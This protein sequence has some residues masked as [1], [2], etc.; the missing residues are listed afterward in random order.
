[1]KPPVLDPRTLAALRQQV[2]ALAA[3]YTPEWRFEGTEDDPG[4]AIAELFCQMMEQAVDR[5]NSVPDNL[6]AHFLDMIGFRLPA[7][8]PASGILQFTVHETVAHPVPVPAATQAFTP[9]SQGDNIVYETERAIEA[10]PAQ[11]LDIYYADSTTDWIEKLDMAQPQAFFAPQGQN[12]QNHRFWLCQPDVLRLTGGCTIELELRQQARHLETQSAAYFAKQVWTYFSGGKEIPFDKVEAQN[13]RLLLEKNTP[14]ALEPDETGNF[15]IA[16]AGQPEAALYLSGVRLRSS[17]IGRCPADAVFAGDLPI[18]LSEGGYCFGRRPAPYGLFYIR[19]DVTLAK[20]GA[21]ANLRLEI[22]PIADAPSE[23]PLQY[24]FTQAIIDKREAVAQKPDDVY[25]AAVVWEYF[26]G[27]GWRQLAVTGDRN[28]FSC[29]RDGALELRFTVPDDLMETEVN[30]QMGYYI[31][32]RIAEV[33]NQFSVYPRWILPLV[34]AVS[35]SW[36]YEQPIPVQCCGAENNGSRIQADGNAT[37]LYLPA[38][39]PMEPAPR[40]M[41]FRFDRS[42]HAM[43]LSLLFEVIGRVPRTDKLVWQAYTGKK[44]EPAAS[45]DGTGNL[46]HTGQVLLYLPDSL[47]YAEFFGQGGYWLRVSRSSYFEMPAPR[48]ATVRLNTV[49]ARQVRAEEPLYFN[50][51]PYEADKTIQLLAAPVVSCAVWVDEAGALPLADAQALAETD[52]QNVTL[53]WEENQ[54]AHAWVRWQAVENLAL[55]APEQRAYVLEPQTGVLRF[56]NGQCGRVP[57]A[58]DGVIRVE[59]ASGGGTRGNVP[60]GKVDALVGSLPRISS[61]VNITPMGGGTDGLPRQRM[62]AIGNR[63]LRHRWRAAGAQDFEELILEAFPQVLHVR[64]FS[65]RDRQ[66]SPAAGHVTVVVDT[67]GGS[68]TTEELCRRVYEFLAARCICCLAAENRL[69]ICPAA[70]LTVSTR[71]SV[72]LDDLDYAAEVQREIIR[73]V[74]LL[75]Q[76]VWQHRQIG[77]QIRMDELWRTVRDTPGVAVIDQILAEGAYDKEGQPGLIPLEEG[78]DFPYAVVQNGI[79]QVRVK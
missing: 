41:Y 20:R 33:E 2:A 37:D 58:G 43:P 17:P 75:I 26:N 12:L 55:A 45:V 30:A 77:S 79:H 6:F 57:P 27:S 65:G 15:C 53:L 40:A 68:H 22:A 24:N 72:T 47:P 4:A 60:A 36:N 42:P 18:D 78:T 61:V 56:G 67:T 49:A 11:L 29:K 13:G 63:R 76:D 38:L 23:Q 51:L 48:V 52:P 44:F 71:I 69:H 28:P 5:F 7:P 74:E 73:Q 50:T 9:D 31:R 64:C 32:A 39:V 70:V 46:H 19:S 21:L 66:G 14:D 3:A 35:F 25:I 10:T 59:Y 62:E 34:K 16:C 8:C 54:L 1:M